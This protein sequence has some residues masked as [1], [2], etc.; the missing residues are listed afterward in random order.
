MFSCIAVAYLRVSDLKIYGGSWLGQTCEGANAA[1]SRLV[2]AKAAWPCSSCKAGPHLPISSACAARDGTPS[3]ERYFVL[4]RPLWQCYLS[5]Q[6]SVYLRAAPPTSKWLQQCRYVVRTPVRELA[7]T[8]PN[9][10]TTVNLSTV[11]AHLTAAAN[12]KETDN[13]KETE[14][15]FRAAVETF[16]SH[17]NSNV[18][19]RITQCRNAE[20]LNN[21]LIR[22]RSRS[23]TWRDER[24]N[25]VWRATESAVAVLDRFR[26][27][28]GTLLQISTN[29]E[30]APATPLIFV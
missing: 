25:P 30:S 16:Q 2:T 12:P 15:L 18:L 24:R 3:S 1:W 23:H 9:Q 14:K 19:Q 22:E 8:M 6:A 28:I 27:P 20:D 10:T 21:N 26:D 17:N 4:P 11:A 5:K 7:I 13:L 29:K